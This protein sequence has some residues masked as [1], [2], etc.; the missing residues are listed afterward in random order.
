[1]YYAAK[2][3]FSARSIRFKR[4]KKLNFRLKLYFRYLFR[5]TSAGVPEPPGSTS[6]GQLLTDA[7]S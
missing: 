5:E 6:T 2:I 7:V 3:G 4:R 1:M